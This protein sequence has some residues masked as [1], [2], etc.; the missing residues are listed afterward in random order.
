MNKTNQTKGSPE[1]TSQLRE[2]FIQS[3][4]SEQKKEESRKRVMENQFRRA[5][6]GK[7]L[8]IKSNSK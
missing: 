1:V 7:K 5:T 8:V 4:S 6:N 2:I 3:A